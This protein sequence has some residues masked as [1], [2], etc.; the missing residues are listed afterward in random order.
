MSE[1]GGVLATLITGGLAAALGGVFTAV[2]QAV[3][4]HGESKAS[5]ADLVTKAAGAMVDR[6]EQEA[7][8]ARAELKELTRENKTLR[9]VVVLLTEV[10]DE[11]IPQ[12][13]A[14]QEALVKLRAAKRAAQRA[15]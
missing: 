14:P 6:L 3:S 9:D 12:L 7:K 15:V 2:L 4:R 8:E 13:D 11:V 5:A 10:L 1:G